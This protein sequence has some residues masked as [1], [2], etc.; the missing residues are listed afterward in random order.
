MF[1]ITPKLGDITSVDGFFADGLSANIS[2]TKPKDWLDIGFLSSDTPCKVEAIFTTNSFQASPLL[3]YQSYPIDF[4]TNFVFINSQNANAMTG[5]QGLQNIAKIDTQLRRKYP[6]ILNPVYSSTGVIGVQL[7]VANI[8]KTLDHIDLSAKNGDNV[9]KAI[10]TTDKYPKTSLYEVTLKDGK[11]FRIGSIAKGAGMIDP[12]MATMLCFICTDADVPKA[13]MKELLSSSNKISFDT[14]SVDGDTSTNDTVILLANA[15]SGAYDRDAFAQ[16]LKQVMKDM[17]MSILSDGEGA[18]KCVEFEV[19]GAADE[20]QAEIIAKKLSNSLLV[21]T[22]LCG[23][24]PNWGRIASTIGASGC[25]VCE[26]SL[27]ISF[28]GTV[29]GKHISVTIYDKAEVNFS[30]DIERQ[31]SSIF[32]TPNFK[33]SCDIGVGHGKYTAYGCDIGHEYIEINSSYRS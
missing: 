15:K 16:A 28:I 33:I 22:A 20:T 30:D 4:Q 17:A 9:A 29:A 12:N 27:S 21:K 23:G 11:T 25:E 5:K 2:T 14:I 31:A 18:T 8:L 32:A 19:V 1:T 13:H 24:D 3:H 26:N 7:P 10:L 6:N